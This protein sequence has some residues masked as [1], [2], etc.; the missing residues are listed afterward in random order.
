MSLCVSG[1]DVPRLSFANASVASRL[2][3]Y[4]EIASIIT[5][6]GYMLLDVEGAAAI[7][8]LVRA[9]SQYALEKAAEYSSRIPEREGD[10]AAAA[11]ATAADGDFEYLPPNDESHRTHTRISPVEGSFKYGGII[12]F[13]TPSLSASDAFL[14]INQYSFN[15][16]DAASFG[17][18]PLSG[19]QLWT[20]RNY[21]SPDG[22]LYTFGRSRSSP[23][24]D[25]SGFIYM[26]SD[27]DEGTYTLPV[28]LSLHPDGTYRWL[29]EMGNDNVVIGAASPIVTSGPLGENRVYFVS[30]DGIASLSEGYAC[31][32]VLNPFRS[33]SG[34]G[35]CN[36]ATGICQCSDICRSGAACEV[37]NTW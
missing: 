35:I 28:L 26:G 29:A 20:F 18:D 14:V 13:A 6:S 37:A 5:P 4:E 8:Q 1:A 36:C 19:A 32:G 21:T 33:C 27:A 3:S 24:I 22:T 23:A 34:H 7:A 16:R 25:P 2:L 30:G 10:A 9:G 17:V 12:P 15:G 11:A 31:P